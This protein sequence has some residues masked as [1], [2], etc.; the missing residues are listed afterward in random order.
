MH[1]MWTGKREIKKSTG[2]Y[3]AD[4]FSSEYSIIVNGPLNSLADNVTVSEC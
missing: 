4:H 1:Q 2:N 3:Y